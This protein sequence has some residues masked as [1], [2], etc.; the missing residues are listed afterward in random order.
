M[1]SAARPLEMTN[2]KSEQDEGKETQYVIVTLQYTKE[3][4]TVTG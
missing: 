3:C 2:T 1:Y 4:E